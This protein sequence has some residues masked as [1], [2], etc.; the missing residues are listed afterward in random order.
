MYVFGLSVVPKYE[1]SIGLVAIMLDGTTNP[2]VI[3]NTKPEKSISRK[4]SFLFVVPFSRDFVLEKVDINLFAITNSFGSKMTKI[5]TTV[6]NN[7]FTTDAFGLIIHINKA[8]AENATENPMCTTFF[9]FFIFKTMF[10][11]RENKLFNIQ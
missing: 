5:A 4:Y 1:N 11:P 2:I 9:G 3:A 10:F 7:F 8:N 6:N